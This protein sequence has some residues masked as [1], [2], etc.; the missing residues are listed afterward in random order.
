[1]IRSMTAYASLS[2]AGDSGQLTWEVK[3]V[4]QRYHEASLRL[5]EDFRVLEPE[6]RARLKARF[7]RGKF[8]VTLRYHADAAAAAAAPVLNRDLAAALLE[9]HRELAGLAGSSA[10]PDLVRLLAWPGLL[11]EQRPDFESEQ[12]NALTLLDD[13][14]DALLEA[15]EREGTAIAEMLEPRLAG[16]LEQAE[17]V[18]RHLP[19]VRNALETRFRERLEGLGADIEPGRMEQEI[20]LQLGKLDVDEE[21]DRLEAHVAEVRRVLTLDEPVGRRLD[22]LMQELNREANTLGSKSVATETTGVSVELKVLIEQMRE[23][24]QNVE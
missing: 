1:M 14:L 12:H 22:F 8:D 15:R 4:N 7:A 17:L 2:R 21:L 9:R 18:R 3:S 20:A 13:T 19:A 6:I 24:V 5:P 16:I 11:I 10:D 23:Q